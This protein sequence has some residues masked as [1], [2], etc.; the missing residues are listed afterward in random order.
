MLPKT[1]SLKF[2]QIEGEFGKKNDGSRNLN[3]YI[4][5]G[6]LVP[7]LADNAKI[8]T[9]SGGKS[10]FSD[11]RGAS[12]HF[13]ANILEY[14]PGDTSNWPAKCGSSATGSWKRFYFAAGTRTYS[15]AKLE[16]ST[17]AL[18]VKIRGDVVGENDPYSSTKYSGVRN[19][20]IRIVHEATGTVV[21]ETVASGT[22]GDETWV[23]L[24]IPAK[25]STTT[26]QGTYRLYTFAE[27][28]TGGGERWYVNWTTRSYYI[29]VRNR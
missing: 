23:S 1:G 15:Y 9:T 16:I 11:F 21:H 29:S 10:D 7:D 19:P 12:D 3:D 22:S 5:G 24:T 25:T 14:T 20:G 8:T 13:S 18:F 6:T 4:R 26:L 2:S 27:C 17:P 28:Y